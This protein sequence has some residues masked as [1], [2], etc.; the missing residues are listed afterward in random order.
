MSGAGGG[1]RGRGATLHPIS[2]SPRTPDASNG[3]AM[4]AP[5]AWNVL[6]VEADAALVERLVR[7]AEV[8]ADFQNAESSK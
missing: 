5:M 6:L 7:S 2:I 8:L 4:A 1:P 3:V